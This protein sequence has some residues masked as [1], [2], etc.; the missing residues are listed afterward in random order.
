M[1]KLWRLWHLFVFYLHLHPSRWCCWTARAL[2][3]ASRCAAV[4]RRA[5]AALLPC[6]RDDR[7]G[8]QRLSPLRLM[9]DRGGSIAMQHVHPL[10]VGLRAALPPPRS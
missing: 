5:I 4:R 2:L 3:G 8:L 6:R 1:Q 7:R 10:M 9:R